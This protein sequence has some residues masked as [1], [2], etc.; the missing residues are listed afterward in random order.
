MTTLARLLAVPSVI[1]VAAVAVACG[2]DELSPEEFRG[3]ANR[4]CVEA[5]QAV[6][7]LD[8]PSSLEQAGEVLDE[9]DQTLQDARDRLQDLETPGGEA[10][11]RAERYVELF[12]EQT[13]EASEA[14]DVLREGIEDEDQEKLE[15]ATRQ[16]QQLENEEIDR[17]AREL[18]LNECV[19]AG[20]AAPTR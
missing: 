5:E 10:G 17:L 2:G 12:D 20:P 18:K 11:E 7:R 3:Q 16:L 8:E 1:A 15:E 4:I 6:E 13:E 14:L 19:G 9:A